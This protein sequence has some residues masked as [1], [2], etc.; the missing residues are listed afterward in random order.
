MLDDSINLFERDNT[1]RPSKVLA[2]IS[3]ASGRQLT[4]AN[5]ILEELIVKPKVMLK[6]MSRTRQL[7]MAQRLTF[8]L[9][10]KIG[11]T[12]AN[13][14]MRQIAGIA[15]EQNIDLKTAFLNSEISQ[16]LTLTELD[17]LLDPT[18][19]K[20]LAAEQVDAVIIEVLSTGPNSCE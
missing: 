10:E 8:G 17:Q 18:T 4:T 20:G 16:H 19:Y 6:I 7:I 11:K 12:T 14:K 5:K 15:L 3:I 2:D 9:A 13:E 1:S